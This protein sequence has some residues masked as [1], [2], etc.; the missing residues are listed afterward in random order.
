MENLKKITNFFFELVSLKR[1]QRSGL[2]VVGVRNSDSVAEHCFVAAQ[3][4]YIL[5]KIENA[6]AEHAAIIALFHDNSESRIGDFNLI[7]HCYLKSRQAEKRAFFD[8]IR[9]LPS[10]ENLRQIFEEFETGNTPEG[11]I[12]R[13]ADK[14]ELAIQAKCT[15]DMGSNKSVQLWI[16]RIRTLLK[17][18]SAKK[19]LE[20][21]EKT[22]MNEWWQA[23]A[24]IQKE[25]KAWKREI[26]G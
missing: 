2:L 18:E 3:I 21:I 23:I 14:L 16:D 6:N 1:V 26:N 11:I 22:D 9:E 20:I 10:K 8:Q 7:H 19:L 25:I 4:A 5:A 17:T 12:A 13:D 24:E 15:L